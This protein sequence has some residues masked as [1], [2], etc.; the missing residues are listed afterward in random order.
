MDLQ[1][2]FDRL[3]K[4]GKKLFT[5]LRAKN[6]TRETD[7]KKLTD[8]QI[9]DKVDRKM[10]VIDSSQGEMNRIYSRPMV[11][12]KWQDILKNL[13]FNSLSDL[14]D[15]I[16]DIQDV[17]MDLMMSDNFKRYMEDLNKDLEYIKQEK[18]LMAATEM[19]NGL[20][21]EVNRLYDD[22]NLGY[23]KESTGMQR[24]I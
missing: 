8:K 24:D 15:V 16:D 12:G 7:Y 18:D 20:K 13:R 4:H 9:L 23:P 17:I 22:Y 5:Y 6:G 10:A 3:D 2:R 21:N 19:L 1:Q 14:H 11:I